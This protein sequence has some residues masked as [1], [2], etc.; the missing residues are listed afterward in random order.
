M[1][2]IHRQLRHRAGFSQVSSSQIN[3]CFRNHHQPQ[4]LQ[5]EHHRLA[6]ASSAAPAIKPVAFSAHSLPTPHLDQTSLE[7]QRHNL[8]REAFSVLRR[9]QRRKQVFSERN[10]DQCLDKV[11]QQVV[12]FSRSLRSRRQQQLH[13]E[14]FSA[15][16][17]LK[18]H[19]LL[20]LPVCLDLRSHHHNNSRQRDL[21]L[22]DKAL[23]VVR[24]QAQEAFLEE[25][26][27]SVDHQLSD[28]RVSSVDK[29]HFPIT[30]V[31]SDNQVSDHQLLP[32]HLCLINKHQRSEPLQRLAVKQLSEVP[33]RTSLDKP[34]PD[35]PTV[36][37]NSLARSRAEIY[38]AIWHK[39]PSSL[40]RR[41]SKVLDSVEAPFRTGVKSF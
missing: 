26:Q 35:N 31:E 17:K 12:R 3:Q 29:R 37:S 4:Q 15:A 14:V 23:S 5:Q 39:T 18:Q 19:R 25:A 7:L 11:A 13:Q 28:Q 1:Q 34:I 32:A 6:V 36:S 38:S 22:E 27:Q 9:Q 10:R 2:T 24:K 30:L 40:S 21:S 16:H 8:Q 20:G 41:H 33:N